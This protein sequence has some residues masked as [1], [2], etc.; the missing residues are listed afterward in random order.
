MKRNNKCIINYNVKF[1]NFISNG[2][3]NF[4]VSS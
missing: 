2:Y 4:V 3:Q 1:Q